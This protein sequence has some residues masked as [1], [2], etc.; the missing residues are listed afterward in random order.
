VIRGGDR[1]CAGFLGTKSKPLTQCSDPEI[2]LA[3]NSWLRHKDWQRLFDA[4]L[5]LPLKHSFPVFKPLGESRFEPAEPDLRSVLR[6]ILVDAENDP[7]LPTKVKSQATSSVF[8]NWLAQGN[9]AP[10]ATLDEG[11][12]LKR[13][14]SA[15]PPEG[16]AIVAALAKKV[17]PGSAAAQ[18]VATNE[19]W[20]VRLAGH[21]T[22]LVRGSLTS[23]TPQDSNDWI[24]ELV[25]SVGVLDFWPAHAKPA[26]LAKLNSAPAEAWSGDLGRARRVLR[27]ILAYRNTDIVVNDVV[28]RPDEFSV[29]VDDD[30]DDE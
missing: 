30:D 28:V 21:A 5:V 22:G 29:V 10:W 6:Q 13:L 12:L 25:A 7:D 26:D 2:Q 19:H 9:S 27:T 24:N 20:L 3:L 15:P 14:A 8:D 16:V 11:E 4:C 17:Q 23:D 1:R 18:A